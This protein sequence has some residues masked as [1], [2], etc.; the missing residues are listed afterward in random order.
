AYKALKAALEKAPDLVPLLVLLAGVQTEMRR[1]EAAA[2]TV[3]KA[4]AIS[5]EALGVFRAEAELAAARGDYAAAE[6]VLKRGVGLY[7]GAPDLLAQ[8]G[9]T[10][11]W[12]GRLEE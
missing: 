7:P 5:A 9:H 12:I 1:L 2:E 8:L 4:R 11:M 10:L 3:T 6:T